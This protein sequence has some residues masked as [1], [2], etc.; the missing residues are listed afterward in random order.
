METYLKAL[1]RGFSFHR[2]PRSKQQPE[3]KKRWN[4]G[5]AEM[6]MFFPS[7]KM[8][9]FWAAKLT[10]RWKCKIILLLFL[11]RQS[12]EGKR[13]L[14]I[15]PQF[16][17]LLNFA[18][19]RALVSNFRSHVR[20]KSPSPWNFNFKETSMAMKNLI[21]FGELLTRNAFQQQRNSI[22][23]PIKKVHQASWI[24]F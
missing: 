2:K 21:K 18:S 19:P 13:L 17:G 4:E 7:I 5:N 8:F 3:R 24:P 1:S 12:R 15:F 6:K 9:F 14:P 22:R 20:G 11:L 16:S 10:K 23:Y